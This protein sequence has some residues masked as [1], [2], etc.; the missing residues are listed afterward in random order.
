MT[1]FAFP[2]VHIALAAT[3]A[4]ATSTSTLY[5]DAVGRCSSK[6]LVFACLV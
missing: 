3:L 4:N 5:V 6:A 2:P 1:C